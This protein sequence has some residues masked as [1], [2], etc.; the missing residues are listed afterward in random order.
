MDTREFTFNTLNEA[1]THARRNSKE[2]FYQIRV[3]NKW[4]KFTPDEIGEI[5]EMSELKDWTLENL[6]EMHI[7]QVA[8]ILGLTSKYEELQSDYGKLKQ[9]CDKTVKSFEEPYE[10]DK[11]VEEF[12]IQYERLKK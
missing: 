9:L 5:K 8:E 1:S 7:D 3:N 11:T 6:K 10:D 2:G 4:E 12:M